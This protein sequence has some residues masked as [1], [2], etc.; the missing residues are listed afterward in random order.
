MRVIRAKHLGMCFGVRDAINLAL[1]QANQAPVT[2]FG[3]L[4]HNE[5]VLSTLQQRGVKMERD[6]EQITTENVLITAHGAS[7]RAM[8]HLRASGRRVAEATCPL[9]H[10]AHNAVR[11]L[12]QEGFHPII[13]GKRDHVEVRGLTGDLDTF[14]VVLSE[15]D[16]EQLGEHPRLGIAAQTTQPIEKV[17]HLVNL[18]RRRFPRSDVR[19][20]DT[21]CQPTKQRQLAVVELAKVVD[22]IVVVGGVA[23]NNTRELT[24]TCR[25][26]CRRVYQVQSRNDLQAGWFSGVES[27]GLTAGTS[28]PDPV[29]EE[30]EQWLET[31]TPAEAVPFHGPG[32]RAPEST[33][34]PISSSLER[35]TPSAMAM[36][37]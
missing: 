26:F 31:L 18:I 15:Q 19:F 30:V 25:R 10:F 9:V 4:V 8:A 6:A 23:S 34:D 20:E 37:D 22:A 27:V 16:V 24:T 29:I 3:E 17:Q 2:V 12:V 5:T 28:T 13:I 11:R 33:G 14:D 36:A 1:Q 21:V 32:S 35:A 7:E